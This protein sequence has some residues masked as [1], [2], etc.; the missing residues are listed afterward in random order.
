ML[1]YETREPRSAPARRS[2]P[3]PSERYT[4]SFA[5]SWSMPLGFTRA[6]QAISQP[7]GATL[8]VDASRTRPRR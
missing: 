4:L 1:P 2:S 3:S 5:G 8:S 6:Q 7:G